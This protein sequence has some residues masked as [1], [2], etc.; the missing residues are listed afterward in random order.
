MEKRIKTKRLNHS[1]KNM[2]KKGAMGSL[3]I[4][5][6]QR[7]V[8]TM[9]DSVTTVTSSYVKS[10]LTSSVIDNIYS[11]EG[12]SL[13]TITVAVREFIHKLAP[14]AYEKFSTE[15]V[16]D[17]SMYT[18]VKPLE[19]CT[20][21]ISRRKC[22][23]FIYARYIE[24]MYD[25]N[26]KAFRT[27]I[28]IT[29]R[30]RKKYVALYNH[31]YR[32][33]EERLSTG[34]TI[35]VV[36]YGKDGE[37]N[38]SIQNKKMISSMVIRED[39]KIAIEEKVQKFIDNK[40]VYIEHEITY[41]LGILL[42][43]A[44]GTGKTSLA[45]ALACKYMCSLV[46]INVNDILDFKDYSFSSA[47]R[48][49]NDKVIVLLEDID[50]VLNDK[51]DRERGTGTT[52]LHKL[53]QILDGV[54]SSD[55][56]IYIATTNYID[57]LDSALTRDGRFDLKIEMTNFRKEEAYQLGHKFNFTREEVDAIFEKNDVTFPVNPAELQNK[58][59][60]DFL[61]KIK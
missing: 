61:K 23:I 39:N 47:R 57:R 49:K 24:N 9:M 30:N 20:F 25:N 56:T 34:D 55:N 27:D 29:G 52:K 42:Y 43:G 10:A 3:K 14:N 45:K 26:V 7:I 35:R 4:L 16:L 28:F 15:A 44:P 18:D 33:V 5:G 2:I 21:V 40:D 48:D 53:L 22:K 12:L 41:K 19:P 6:A 32:N 60:T 37:S 59:M 58:L 36:E 1:T 46:V 31:I 17:E 13:P 38:T 50:C 54:N 8:D 11:I 51:D